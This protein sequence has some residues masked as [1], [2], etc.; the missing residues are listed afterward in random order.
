MTFTKVNI[1]GQIIHTSKS[2]LLQI[3]YF[4][5]RF[6][7]CESDKKEKY[8]GDTDNEGNIFVDRSYDT[9]KYILQ[10]IKYGKK[11]IKLLLNEKLTLADIYVLHD[12]AE[13]YKLNVL[14]DIVHV[15]LKYH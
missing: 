13:Y 14:S 2:T 1:S 11:Y 7:Y 4:K 3:P 5:E 9:F 6:N 8:T 10:Y 12:D 15:W